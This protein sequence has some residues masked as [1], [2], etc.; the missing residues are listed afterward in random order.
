MTREGEKKTPLPPFPCSMKEVLAVLRR[1]L[2][3]R[4]V[5]PQPP[6]REPTETNKDQSNYCAY[7]QFV[8]HTTKD[9]WAFQSI[10]HYKI[11]SGEIVTTTQTNIEEALHQ[12]YGNEGIVNMVSLHM[13]PHGPSRAIPIM[14]EV[15]EEEL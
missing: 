4:V 3:D 7:H 5:V 12:P 10:F 11:A 9:S 2:K 15:D 1:W 14:E 6:V 13:V 8:K